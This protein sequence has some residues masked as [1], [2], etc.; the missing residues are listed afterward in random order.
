MTVLTAP[1]AAEKF[2]ADAKAAGYT[3]TT[4]AREGS[5]MVAVV[6]KRADEKAPTDLYIEWAV[7]NVAPNDSRLG[8]KTSYKPG[9]RFQP[10]MIRV[11]GQFHTN[12]TSLR[13]VRGHLGLVIK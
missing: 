9:V 4:E 3:V 10:A 2:V 7:V 13:Q 5:Y 1:K 12:V 11:R 8:F 6:D